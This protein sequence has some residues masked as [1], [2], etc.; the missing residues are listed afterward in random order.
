MQYQTDTSTKSSRQFLIFMLS[1]EKYGVD[2]LAVQELRG[3]EEATRIPNT[4]SFVLGIINVRGL[5]IPVIDLHERFGM[6][7]KA[8]GSTTAVI[9]IRQQYQKVGR[10]I[11]LVV[12][13]VS[14]VYDISGSQVQ[15]PP[16]MDA[17]FANRFVTG[18]ASMDQHMIILLDIN[19]LIN[20]GILSQL[21]T[22]QALAEAA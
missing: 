8:Y 21:A 5:V 12:D 9:I 20:N 14:D 17:A 7:R 16:D 19:T 11:G 3:W 1:G 6:K 22:D 15:P 13:A 10:M 4:P 18:L 2:I